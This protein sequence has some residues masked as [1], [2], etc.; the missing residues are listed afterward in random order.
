MIKTVETKQS[1]GIVA[2]AAAATEQLTKVVEALA[3]FDLI[4]QLVI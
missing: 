3:Q 4:V 2:V 1:D